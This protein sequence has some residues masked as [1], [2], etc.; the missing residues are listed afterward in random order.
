MELEDLRIFVA[1]ATDGTA[2]RAARRLAMT[3]PGVSQH[4]A[5]LESEVGSKQIGRASCRERV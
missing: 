1:V 5:R 3:Q 4:I 2:T